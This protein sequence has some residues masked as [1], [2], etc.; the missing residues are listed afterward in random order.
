MD[1][2]GGNE[3]KKF[4]EILK[5]KESHIKKAILE[6]QQKNKEKTLIKAILLWFGRA[7]ALDWA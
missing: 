7:N 3:R 4:N 1:V 5:L 6:Q 2:C